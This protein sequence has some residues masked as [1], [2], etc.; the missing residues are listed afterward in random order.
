MRALA[1]EAGLPVVEL[2]IDG[3]LTKWY[4][5]SERRLASIFRLCR[6]A[7]R[8]I[9]L[10]DEIDALARHRRDAHEAS[11]RLVSILLMEMDGL[12]RASDLLLVGAA[13]DLGGID[14]AVLS[15]FDVQ[16][17]F[18]LPGSAALESVLSYYARQLPADE[19]TELAALMEGWTFRQVA[20]FAQD[21]VRSYVA[22]L[23]LSLL[24]A[25]D[26]PLP[27]KEDYL[28]ALA[29]AE[30]RGGD[31]GKRPTLHRR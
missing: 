20:R 23:D 31:E 6:Q 27:R 18:G 11:A 10:V 15:R 4:G 16:I 14:E 24:E 12:G 1:G 30:A 7:G 17:E 13:N 25:S 28:A 22:A 8:M 19:I 2:P 29:P 3:V 9:L 26:P 5:E 21:V